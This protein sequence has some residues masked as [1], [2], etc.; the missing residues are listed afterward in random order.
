MRS[1]RLRTLGV[2]AIALLTTAYVV[3]SPVDADAASIVDQSQ[4]LEDTTVIN[5][6]NGGGPTFHCGQIFTVGLTGTLTQVDLYLESYFGGT[7]QGVLFTG[8]PLN[9]APTLLQTSPTATAFTTEG[10]YS[11]NFNYAVTTGDVLFFGVV[12]G[13]D[14]AVDVGGSS[15]GNVYAGGAAATDSI[16]GQLF[17]FVGSDAA[18]RTFVDTDS[19][20]PVP[21]PTS[22]TLLGLGLAG[23]AGRRWRQRKAS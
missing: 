22:L 14:Q 20:A 19:A 18:F 1:I 7:P 16:P 8:S 12:V 9:V 4:L 15:L 11:F 6:S 10:F 17:T 13:A 2:G 23:M 21:E 5:C 3:A